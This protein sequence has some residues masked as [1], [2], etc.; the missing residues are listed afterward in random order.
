[1]LRLQAPTVGILDVLCSRLIVN[2][3]EE[4]REDPIRLCSQ[5]ELAYWFYLGCCCLDTPLYYQPSMREF[6]QM[7]FQHTLSL[8]E[9]LPNVDAILDKWT[10]Y[11][12]AVPTFGAVLIDESLEKVLLVHSY[13]AKLTWSFPIGNVKE[14]QEL[15]ICAAREVLKQTGFDITPFV[16]KDD[17]IEGKI[18]GQ[19]TRLYMIAGVPLDTQFS[20]RTCKEIRCIHWFDIADL[21]A[22]KFEES[23]LSSLGLTANALF[24]VMPFV[25]KIRKWI[26]NSPLRLSRLLSGDDP[27]SIAD[28]RE[29]M[30]MNAR[31][32]ASLHRDEAAEILRLMECSEPMPQRNSAKRSSKNRDH[33]VPSVSRGV[34]PDFL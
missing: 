6:A 7:M 9:H 33:V 21:P 17:F 4:E 20:P 3:P 34:D 28:I 30:Q 32:Y 27:P 31:Y 14:E 15:H 23:P 5:V 2:T 12:R 25:K 13:L 24:M 19:V 1:M 10:E 26:F 22:N 18:H 11:K 8:Q 16:S 29:A